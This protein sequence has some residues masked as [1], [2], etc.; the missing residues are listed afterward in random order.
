MRMR[1]FKRR[2]RGGLSV[3]RAGAG[4]RFGLA[5]GD[6]IGCCVYFVVAQHVLATISCMSGSSAMEYKGGWRVGSGTTPL[7]RPR[8]APRKPCATLAWAPSGYGSAVGAADGPPFG[9]PAAAFCAVTCC[10][11]VV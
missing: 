10:A 9:M 7:T 1:M 6:A 11:L 4:A 2:W 8:M 5:T 3:G